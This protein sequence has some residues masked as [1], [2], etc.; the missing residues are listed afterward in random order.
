M[1]VHIIVEVLPYEGYS[2]PI[3]I[4]LNEQKAIEECEILNRGRSARGSRRVV[5]FIVVSKDVIE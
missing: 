1:R 4:H 2:E 3:S 5:Y